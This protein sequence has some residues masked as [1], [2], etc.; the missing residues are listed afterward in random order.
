MVFN[1]AAMHERLFRFKQ[2]AVAHE[3]SAM[4]V[5]VDGVL[6][7]A[8]AA[9]TP[10]PRRILDVGCGCGLIALML[11]QRTAAEIDAVDVDAPSVEEARE[12]FIASPW[13]DRLHALRC[14][15]ADSAERRTLRPGYDIIISNPPFFDSGI[16][17]PDT[18]RLL[19]RH[20]STLNPLT[21]LEYGAELLAPAG[22]IAII[23]PPAWLEVL[24]ANDA[25]LHLRR[26]AWVSGRVGKKPK[27]ILSEW[28]LTDGAVATE[29]L[30]LEE[31][32]GVPTEAH[33]R[34]CAP[35]YLRF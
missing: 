15:F 8:W 22:T 28:S 3:A 12:N 27:R 9:T 30:A 17:S 13:N 1:F 34:L 4:K 5:G 33:R 24:R 10:P 19:A 21:V 26:L 32:P 18:P 2:F 6:L 16:D 25:T 20:A 7:G 31:A 23:S 14:D 29:H 35:F 11:A